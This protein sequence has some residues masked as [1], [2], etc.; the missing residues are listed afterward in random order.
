MAWL[1]LKVCGSAAALWLFGANSAW[2]SPY[3]G[4]GRL[5]A[6]AI[7]WAAIWA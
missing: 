1:G 3:V 5:A 7:A 2:P 6:L 4:L